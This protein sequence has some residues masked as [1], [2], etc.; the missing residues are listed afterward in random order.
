MPRRPAK[1]QAPTLLA[2]NV[3][4]RRTAEKYDVDRATLVAQYITQD[5]RRPGPERALIAERGVSVAAVIAYLESVD[6]D[7]TRTAKIYELPV[8]A[9]E[10]AIAYYASHQPAID[11]R[12]AA[13]AAFHTA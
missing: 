11:A 8:A 10:A 1:D 4:Q 3:R 12:I 2:P 13:Q 7:R 6:W 5:P 9:V